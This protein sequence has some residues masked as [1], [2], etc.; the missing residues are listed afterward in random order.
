MAKLAIIGNVAPF[1]HVHLNP[2]ECVFAESDAMVTMDACLSLESSAKGGIISSL[3]RKFAND[4]SF[5]QQKIVAPRNQEG[6][7]LLAPKLPGEIM[8]L[9]VGRKQYRLADG[10]FLAMTENVSLRT[11]SQGIGKAL[12]GSTGGFLLMETEGEGMV[13]VS[14]LG[15]IQELEVHPGADMI[16]DNS[17]VVAWDRELEYSVAVNTCKKGMFSGIWHGITGGEG[18]V[19]RFSGEGKV[20]ICSR[21]QE[22]FLGWIA[23][24]LPLIGKE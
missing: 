17:H 12:F 16:V 6:E 5:F 20:C 19:L 23:G 22:S 7:I 3:F 9:T 24:N 15:S 14:G 1:L 21:S 8:L 18:L 11:K 10:A 4:E 13:A 2:G